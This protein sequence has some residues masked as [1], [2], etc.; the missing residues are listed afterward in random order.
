MRGAEQR[1]GREHEF[2]L[3]PNNVTNCVKKELL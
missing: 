2:H 3:L 1:E